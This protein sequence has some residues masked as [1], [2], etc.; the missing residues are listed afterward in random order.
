MERMSSDIKELAAALI[1]FHK[2][3]PKLTM[4]SDNPFFKSRYA[5]LYTILDTYTPTLVKCGLAVYQAPFMDSLETYL[6]HTSGQ[7]VMSSTPIRSKDPSNPQAIG[8]AIT[9]ARRY[10]LAAILSIAADPD[11]DG[12]AATEP[13]KEPVTEEQK[14]TKKGKGN[15]EL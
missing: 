7:Y 12:N 5:S 13:K 15:G 11:D 6:I 3:A 14:S 8:S 2:Q 10:G 4:D 9:Y 1:E